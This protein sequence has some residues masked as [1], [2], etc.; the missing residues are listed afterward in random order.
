[1]SINKTV[2]CIIDGLG[3]NKGEFGNAIKAADMKNLNN[4]IANF[5]YAE[6]NASGLEVGLT[7]PKDAGN[8][9]VGH[10]AI[11]SGQHIKQGL[12]LLNDLIETG[13]I[14]ESDSWKELVKNA[15]GSKLNIFN[16]LS[17]GRI[18]SDMYSHLFPVLKRCAKEGVRVA[19]HGLLDGRDV[20]TQ[21]AMKYIKDV[22]DFITEHK[23]DAKIAT[24]AGRSI[25]VMDR[26]ETDTRLLTNVVEVCVRG[27]APVISDIEKAIND[28][29]KARP[30]MTDETIPAFILEPDWLLK[31]GDSVLLLNYRGDRAVQLCAMFETGKYLD[32]EQYAEIDKCLF[33]GVL[34][35]D[36]ELNLP[37]KYLCPPPVIKNT[38]SE[39]LVEHGVRQYSVTETV[40]FGHLTY[41]FN[42]NRAKPFD[43]KLEVW[44]EFKSDVLASMYNQAPKM[45]AEKITDD[46]CEAIQGGKYDFIKLNLSNPDMVGHT[47]DFDATVIACRV[48]DDCLGKLITVCRDNKVNLIITSDHGN[49]EFMKYEDGKPQSSHTSSLVPFIVMPFAFCPKKCGVD[50]GCDKLKIKDGEF[51]LTNIAATV[52]ELLGIEVSPHFNQAIIEQG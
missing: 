31:N 40:K 44:K 38:L 39:W 51:G 18:H 25:L 7:D 14:F 45:Q 16:K 22:Q 12:A 13:E 30:N 43:T 26:Y 37:K 21:S 41:F 32:K 34:Q 52:C 27:K 33:A 49:A 2:L 36:A 29:Y 10:N 8:S 19:I 9:E 47:G 11:G 20:A 17:G 35:Y 50:H 4:A 1:M 46:A 3:I 5:P 24:V 15:K 23:V 28:E 6:I 42:G 48:V